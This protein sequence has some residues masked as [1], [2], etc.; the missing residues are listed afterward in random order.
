MT[1]VGRTGS[2]SRRCNITSLFFICLFYWT[3]KLLVFDKATVR[4]FFLFFPTERDITSRVESMLWCSNLDKLGD[5]YPR[6]NISKNVRTSTN[7]EAIVQEM[8]E[9][10]FYK[11][12]N[13]LWTMELRIDIRLRLGYLV[14]L[15]IWSLHCVIYFY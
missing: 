6:H 7:L 13:S 12:F 11:F 10:L 4:V 15:A 14:S 5:R 2:H 1:K 9:N 3:W 8:D